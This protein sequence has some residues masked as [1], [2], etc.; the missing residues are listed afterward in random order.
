MDVTEGPY[1]SIGVYASE[2]VMA[3]SKDQVRGLIIALVPV[4]FVVAIIL[5]MMGENI[6]AGI[7][8]GGGALAAM[9]KARKPTASERQVE[10]R[11]ESAEVRLEDAK[12]SIIELVDASGKVLVERHE[13]LDGKSPEEKAALG[14]VLLDPRYGLDAEDFDPNTGEPL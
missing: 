8:A 12:R 10:R 4:A 11:V 13:D 3:L 14:M 7:L 9:F 1:Y 6:G 5:W 2:D